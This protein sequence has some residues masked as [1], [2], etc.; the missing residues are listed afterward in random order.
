VNLLVASA[1]AGS[2]ARI[3]AHPLDTLKSRLM[4]SSATR[5]SQS[6]SL[7]SVFISTFKA[8]GFRGLYRGFWFTAISSLPASCLYF[9]TQEWSRK[10]L[11]N[12][13]LFSGF[14][15]ETVSC[16]IYV[17]IDVVKERMQVQKLDPVTGSYGSQY[18]NGVKAVL[19]IVE[20]EGILGLYKGYFSTL[21]SFGPFSA[22]Y[23]FFY[24]G[25]RKELLA[26]YNQSSHEVPAYM[27][28]LGG[29]ICGAGAAFL[30]TPLDLIKLRKQLDPA[31]PLFYSQGTISGLRQIM[32][33]EGVQGLFRGASARVSYFSPT[34][35]FSMALF[36]ILKN[37]LGA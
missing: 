18:N 14:F 16:L 25:Y 19:G 10:N 5:G 12:N 34:T 24:E 7:R 9:T 29:G 27:F 28:W 23:F 17:P 6:T 30:T 21:G 26:V 35:A 22:L 2:L 20:R 4:A 1:L 11:F 36:E 8:E 15:A 31:S 33:D 32:K 37:E 13:A 3:P